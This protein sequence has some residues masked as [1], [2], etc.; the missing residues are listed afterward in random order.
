MKPKI[1]IIAVFTLLQFL[2]VSAQNLQQIQNALDSLKSEKSILLE[3]LEELAFLEVEYSKLIGELIMESSSGETFSAVGT[4]NLYKEPGCYTTIARINKGDLLKLIRKEEN[5]CLVLFKGQE[6]YVS[7][8][9]L[10]RPLPSDKTTT[11]TTTTDIINYLPVSNGEVVNHS[12]YS[13]SYSEPNEQAEWVY[14]RL[15]EDLLSGNVSRTDNFKADRFI[16]TLSAGPK[17]YSGSGYD[18]GHL[19]PAGDMTFNTVAM[20]ESFYMSNMSPQSPSFNRGIWQTLEGTVRH[21]A[22][23]E[24]EL[25][26]VTGPIFKDNLGVLAAGITIPGYFYKVIYDPTDKQKM[27]GLVLPNC[28][29]E[30]QLHEYAVSVDYI[31]ELTGVD[32]FAGLPDE[33]ENEL[34]A[35]FDVSHWEFKQFNNSKAGGGN[36]VQCNAIAKSTGQRCRNKTTN[37]NSFCHVHQNQAGEDE[38]KE[39]EKRLATSVQCKGTTKSGTRCKNKTLNANEYCHLH[40]SQVKSSASTVTTTTK[41]TTTTTKTPSS[42]GSSSRTIH[43]GPRGGK[44]YIN[45]SGN[46]TYIK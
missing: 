23:V 19:C 6:G 12:Y 1:L 44:Y 26:V 2:N 28:K 4:T 40:Q 21:W 25:H 30:K 24:K 38:K 11:T 17:D 33:L 7:T 45:S 46:K 5:S 9:V 34:E 3:R 14:Y 27:I 42:T 29:G 32:F 39:D 37:E 16:T 41:T 36:S 13:L 8:L 15:S 10:D 18:R 43:T 22:T 31:E 20:N 35:S